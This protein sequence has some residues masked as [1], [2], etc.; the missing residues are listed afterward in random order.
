MKS[1]A[2]IFDM[3]DTL[4]PESSYVRSGFK[5]VAKWG[6]FELGI[7]CPASTDFLLSAFEENIRGNTFNLWLNHFG[8]SVSSELISRV[9]DVYRS[10]NPEISPY[11]GVVQIL[12]NLSSEYAIG[13]VSDG[14]LET[15]KKKFAALSLERFFGAV[16]FSDQLGRENWKPSPHP[17]QFVSQKLNVSAQNCVY[18]GDN[19]TKDFSG[20]RNAGM[21]S[22][23]MRNHGGQYSNLEPVSVYEN[24]NAEIDSLSE[25][26]NAVRHLFTKHEQG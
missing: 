3:D 16:C 2:I 26:E 6:E 24:P 17:F 20:A 13:L 18:V 14:Y 7:P 11:V 12:E 9:V 23:R 15:Q 22:I 5:A 8:Q 10:H 4:F 21:L 19:P 25:L 1:K